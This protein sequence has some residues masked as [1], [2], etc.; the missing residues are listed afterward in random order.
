MSAFLSSI[1]LKGL[2]I[3]SRLKLF[4]MRVTNVALPDHLIIL[5]NDGTVSIATSVAFDSTH[6]TPLDRRVRSVSLLGQ[7]YSPSA[8]Q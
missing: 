6:L 5:R 8:M 4:P 2:C 3:F 7:P 1:G